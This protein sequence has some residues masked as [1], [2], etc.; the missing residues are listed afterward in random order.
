MEN[1]TRR[2]LGQLRRTPA[3]SAVLVSQS[4]Q[5][6]RRACNGG[7][8]PPLCTPLTMGG[9][10][11]K[12]AMKAEQA[13]LDAAAPALTQARVTVW[14]LASQFDFDMPDNYLA[15]AAEGEY[16]TPVTVQPA[17]LDDIV[18]EASVSRRTFYENFSD[19]SGCLI[20]LYEAASGNALAVLRRAVPAGVVLVLAHRSWPRAPA[21]PA[22]RRRA[23]AA[24]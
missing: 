20:A 1:P 10:P 11:E 2:R 13:T 3:K 15:W 6:P 21:R 22:V 24:P 17:H 23:A 9:W 8:K 7:Q 16:V 4:P 14:T 5:P 18:R 12:A 19:K